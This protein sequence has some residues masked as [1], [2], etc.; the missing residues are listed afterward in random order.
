MVADPGENVQGLGQEAG[1]AGG[2][3]LEA[4]GGGGEAERQE[5]GGWRLEAGGRRLEAGGEVTAAGVRGRGNGSGDSA[6][7]RLY[8]RHE[9]VGFHGDH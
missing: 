4:G 1:E 7:L 2:R 5:A 9:A 8:R 3:R 6:A